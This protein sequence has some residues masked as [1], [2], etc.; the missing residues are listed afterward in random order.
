M[1]SNTCRVCKEGTLQE[2][3]VVRTYHPNNQNVEVQLLES[4]CEKCGAVSVSGTQHSENLRRLAARKESYGDQLMGEE[5]IALRKRYGLTQRQASKIFGKGLIAFSRYENEES[6]PDASTRLL[7]ELAISRPEILK[8]LADKAGVEIPLWKEREEDRMQAEA[9]QEEDR[10][11]AETKPRE[12]R[13][14]AEAK[15]VRDRMQAEAK[16]INPQRNDFE[17][18]IIEA[19]G[20]LD[21]VWFGTPPLQGGPNAYMYRGFTPDSVIRKRSLLGRMAPTIDTEWLNCTEGWAILN[22][23]WDAHVEAQRYV[24]NDNLSSPFGDTDAAGESAIG[25]AAIGGVAA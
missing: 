20:L 5:Y 18:V 8:T 22:R 12:D 16:G 3:T 9:K 21:D 10:M 23:A 19:N 11:R 25:D 15:K 24:F 7:I 4:R 1:K 13:L 17:S 2:S 14:Q 6:Y